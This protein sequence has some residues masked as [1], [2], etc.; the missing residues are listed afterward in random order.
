MADGTKKAIEE[1]KPGDFVLAA[2]HLDPE[3]KPEAARVVRF[4]DNGLIKS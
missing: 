3:R 2:D 4:F 1:I